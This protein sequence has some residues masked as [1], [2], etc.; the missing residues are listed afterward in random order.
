MKT[1]RGQLGRTLHRVAQLACVGLAFGANG[2]GWSPGPSSA[3]G[4]LSGWMSPLPNGGVLVGGGTVDI[5]ESYDGA[6]NT[7]APAAP[8]PGGNSAVGAVCLPNGKVLIADFG[9]GTQVYDALDGGWTSLAD[10]TPGVDNVTPLRLANGKIALVTGNAGGSGTTNA[11]SILDPATLTWTVGPTFYASGQ[12]APATLLRDGRLLVAGGVGGSASNKAGTFDPTNNTWSPA[13]DLMSSPGFLA[14]LPNGKVLSFGTNTEIYDPAANAW[15]PGPNIPSPVYRWNTAV[16]LPNGHVVVLGANTGPGLQTYD[17][18]SNGWSTGPASAVLRTDGLSTVLPNGRVLYY[19]GSTELRSSEIY[20]NFTPRF[21]GR[22]PLSSPRSG[23]A[24]TLLPTDEVLVAGG[25]DAS[26]ALST[27]TLYVPASDTW[28][29]TGSLRTARTGHRITLLRGGA[30]LVTG[31][32]DASGNVTSSAELFN[33]ATAAWTTVAQMA[34]ARTGHTTTTL[35]D[36]TV[37]VIGGAAS[38]LTSAERF[39]PGSNQW[40]PVA[41]MANGRSGHTATLLPGAKVL[42]CGGGSTT[43]ELYGVATG[44]WSLAAA[45]AATAAGSTATLLPNGGVLLTV[46][47]TS[48]AQVYTPSTNSWG[49]VLTLPNLHESATA[50]LLR[51]GKVAVIGKLPHAS[52]MADL[53]DY[54]SGTWST[55][56]A[57]TSARHAHA[58]VALADGRVLLVGGNGASG[59]LASVDL[60]DEG[61]DTLAAATP[62]LNAPPAADSSSLS[63]TGSLFFGINTGCGGTTTCSQTNFPLL[64]VENL[65]NAQTTFLATTNWTSTSASA[66]VPSSLPFGSY[67]ASVIVNGAQSVSRPWTYVGGNGTQLAF[68]TPSRTFS[69][70]EC[71]GEANVVS[72][73]L[74]NSVGTPVNALPGGQSFSIG[75][76]STG[77]VTWY[78]DAACSQAAPGGLFTLPAGM[79]TLSAYYV[80]T[81]AGAV[82]FTTYS[83][84]TTEAGPQSHTVLGTGAAVDLPVTE[85]LSRLHLKTGC[86]CGTVEPGLLPLGLVLF[87]A[88]RRRPHR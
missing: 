59:P 47:G 40:V 71:G 29:P 21:A 23:A 1:S 32:T 58:A 4:H 45:P 80:D 48:S 83:G 72:V 31:G 55:V 88:R 50:T 64:A 22:A 51:N 81:R 54:V 25:A 3:E 82:L 61:R 20:D 69:A 77:T 5:A 86:G 12:S 67:R 36:G 34:R 9:G 79:H 8:P 18:V 11:M 63:I 73:Q 30:V 38:D 13:P 17:P 52:L 33:R 42:V 44:T 84:L 75:S 65:E 57:V 7:F 14:T 37:L 68:L 15:I 56:N 46:A 16:I 70:G 49:P 76:T 35:A 2:A 6:P 62:V 85:P 27:A 19:G 53:Y 28:L 60:F 74:Q 26:G 41:P 10:P 43:C 24:A 66:R 78:A 39:V 87:L